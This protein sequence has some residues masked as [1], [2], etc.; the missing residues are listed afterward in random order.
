MGPVRVVIVGGSF[1]G[2]TPAYELRR[3]LTPERAEI[4]LVATTPSPTSPS[5]S[6][7]TPR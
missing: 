4:T 7:G 5:T 3:R 6:K 2:L 1:G